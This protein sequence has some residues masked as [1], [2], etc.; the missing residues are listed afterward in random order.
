[1]TRTELEQIRDALRFHSVGAAYH[2]GAAQ[3][4]AILDAE[5]AKPEAREWGI[6]S[7]AKPDRTGDFIGGFEAHCPVKKFP[8]SEARDWVARFPQCYGLVSRTPAGPWESA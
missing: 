1:M 4:L 5:L 7:I 8:E 2:T 3:A 6:V